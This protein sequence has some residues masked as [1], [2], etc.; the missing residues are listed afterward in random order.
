MEISKKSMGECIMP[1][2]GTCV[3]AT[4]ANDIATKLNIKGGDASAILDDAKKKTKCDTEA[5]VIVSTFSGKDAYSILR[6]YIKPSGP[7]Y[8]DESIT[9]THIDHI[10]AQI[11]D[12]HNVHHIEYQMMDFDTTKSELS[13]LDLVDVA[14][15]K[16]SGVAVVLN[17]DVS[18]GVGKHWV[19]VYCDLTKPQKTLE[20]FNSSGRLP[21][22][23]VQVCFDR[24][25]DKLKGAG[26][27]A[28]SVVVSDIMHQ[29][30]GSQCGPYV[31]YYLWSRMNG[32]P[33]SAFNERRIPNETMQEFRK[34]IFR[35][36]QS[37]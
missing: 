26:F 23:E 7:R 34:V 21:P 30:G 24:S 19:C 20:Y 25:I 18:T 33:Y 9:N 2:N 36:Q 17:T 11:C 8:V 31:I 5:C 10:L 4:V 29:I 12:H 37:R 15:S 28:R 27:D 35:P 1:N 13:C 3:S 22:P 6:K 14:K 16:K 32:T